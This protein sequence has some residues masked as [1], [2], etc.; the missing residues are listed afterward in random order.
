MSRPRLGRFLKGVRG[1]LQP[2]DCITYTYRI[3][4]STIDTLS[5]VQLGLLEQNTADLGA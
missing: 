3:V 5:T 4:L 1:F 2:Q